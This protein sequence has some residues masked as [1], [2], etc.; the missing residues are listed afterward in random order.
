MLLVVPFPLKRKAQRAAELVTFPPSMIVDPM[1]APLT[2]RFFAPTVM[3]VTVK[4]PGPIEIV[5]P[6]TALVKA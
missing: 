5:S 3:F 4:V 2:V 1:P 6:E